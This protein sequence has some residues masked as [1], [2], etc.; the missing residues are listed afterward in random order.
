MRTVSC[1][2]KIFKHLLDGSLFKAI[3]NKK[4]TDFINNNMID[5]IN[6]PQDYLIK[7]GKIKLG[8]KMDLS[9]P[10]TFNEKINWYKLNYENELMPIVVDK[11]KA[12][13]Y[14]SSKGLDDIL[15]K[16]I[17]VYNK[18]D[19]INYEMLPE[20][21]VVK[22]TLD[23]GG[24]YVCKNKSQLKYDELNKK[25]SLYDE[26]IKN[27]VHVSL[28]NIY[29]KGTNHIIVEEL[30]KTPNGR[31]PYDYKFFCF[32]GE[33]RFLFV[34]SDRESEVK[35]DFFDINF[36]W[37]D[38]R[39]GHKNNKNRPIKPENYEKMIDICR[40]LSKDFPQVRV[41]LYNVDG[42][43]Y[44]GELTFYH[45]AGLT[46]FSPR[47]WDKIFGSYWDIDNK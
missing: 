19:E 38:V 43:I 33:P 29:C 26:Q 30:I 10:Q 23:S 32:N 3:R 41:D 28:E 20:S 13:E 9:N 11:E 22:N 17:G 4:A 1:I 24:V 16:T 44:F 21:F 39:Q 25:I 5:A 35:F 34:G 42:K 40:I 27:G 47:K 15:V 2:K 37:L 12:K 7:L 31:N 8:Y 14:V 36:N 18:I 6:N 46:R 45:F